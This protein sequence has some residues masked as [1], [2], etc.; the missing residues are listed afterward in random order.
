MSRRYRGV[1]RLAQTCTRPVLRGLPHGEQEDRL[2]VRLT[3]G[4]NMGSC[5]LEGV[6]MIFS[7]KTNTSSYG[8]KCAG[9]QLISTKC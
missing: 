7:M 2:P 5:V 8:I 1:T 6:I 3:R 9:L 4:G